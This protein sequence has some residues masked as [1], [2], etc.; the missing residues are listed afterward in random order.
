MTKLQKKTEGCS[1]EQKKRLDS[2]KCSEWKDVQKA[3]LPTIARL[4]HGRVKTDKD[5][6]VEMVGGY[7]K[8]GAH[9]G[10]EVGGEAL[11]HYWGKIVERLYDGSCQWDD[12]LSL[13]DQLKVMAEPVIDEAVKAYRNRQKEEERLG[14]DSTPVDFDV[15]W[16]GEDESLAEISTDY[17][18]TMWETIC[19]AADGDAELEAFVQVTGES[20]TMKEVNERLGL[21]GDDRDRLLKRLK[22][23]VQKKSYPMGNRRGRRKKNEK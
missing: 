9:S 19:E 6:H 11:Y 3:V 13:T 15:D 20:E 4:L 16:L 22:R 1:N 17:R 21:K 14:I 5:G 12:E 2:V 10:S 18:H 8:Y 7:T 23:K